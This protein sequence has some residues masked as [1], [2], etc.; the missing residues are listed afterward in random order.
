MREMRAIGL[1]VLM[2]MPFASACQSVGPAPSDCAYLRP[3]WVSDDDILTDDTARQILLN[4][5]AWLALC[6][7]A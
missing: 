1:I 3:I 6:V 7:E 2:M 4:N 5:E